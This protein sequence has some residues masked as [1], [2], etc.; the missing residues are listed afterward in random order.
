MT[1]EGCHQP[2]QLCTWSQT[3]AA[4]G[5]QPLG[6]LSAPR[7]MLK[8]KA[9][10]VGSWLAK[11]PCQ[12]FQLMPGLS[13]H[14]PPR[15]P[16][17]ALSIRSRQTVSCAVQGLYEVGTLAKVENMVKH[18]SIAGAQLLLYGHT[19]IRRLDVVSLQTELS[20]PWLRSALSHASAPTPAATASAQ[21]CSCCRP[22]ALRHACLGEGT[23]AQIAAQAFVRAGCAAPQ[24]LNPTSN[25]ISNL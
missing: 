4:S 20:G 2:G 6:A 21:A 18:D 13:P 9:A 5:R 23:E 24:T 15:A 16:L 1:C 19:R 14:P 25:P 10:A 3:L 12:L 11:P 7:C 8:A 17:T 22:A